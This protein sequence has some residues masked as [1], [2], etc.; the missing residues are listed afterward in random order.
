CARGS[1][2]GGVCYIDAVFY[3]FDVW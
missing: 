2:S 3:R 1:C